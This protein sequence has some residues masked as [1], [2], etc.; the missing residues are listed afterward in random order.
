MR[1][2]TQIL[3]LQRFHGDVTS[4]N[5]LFSKKSENVTFF[6]ASFKL[7]IA[8][9]LVIIY[10]LPLGPLQM[11]LSLNPDWTFK[12]S[13]NRLGK[14]LEIFCFCWLN[15]Q[16]YILGSERHDLASFTNDLLPSDRNKFT[17][18]MVSLEVFNSWFSKHFLFYSFFWI[19]ILWDFAYVREER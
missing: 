17:L 7:L 4:M 8:L 12:K 10:Y 15:T 9:L 16:K 1:D 6:Q 19:S 13:E 5:K 2:S 18:V 14:F 3:D 11:H